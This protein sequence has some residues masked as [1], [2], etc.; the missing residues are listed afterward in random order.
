MWGFVG[1]VMTLW[2]EIVQQYDLVQIQSLFGGRAKFGYPPSVGSVDI[3]LP[4]NSPDEP[5]RI[6]EGDMLA[7]IISPDGTAWTLAAQYVRPECVHALPCGQRVAFDQFVIDVERPYEVQE[8]PISYQKQTIRHPNGKL[9]YIA[10]HS[11]LFCFGESG[12][13]WRRFG[14]FGGDFHDLDLAENKL[15]CGG[16]MDWLEP[17]Q[18]Q[19]VLDAQTGEIIG[20]DV[21]AY[22][23][24]GAL[25]SG[26]DIYSNKLVA[27][28]R[29]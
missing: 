7:Q 28:L 6:C 14:V 23:S 25:I 29:S 19:V 10:D 12:P 4:A 8:I 9:F 16:S 22:K 2:D 15:I 27:S 1:G 18:F 5:F 3:C 20:G 21:E 17:Q 24:A 13:L 26:N 11:E